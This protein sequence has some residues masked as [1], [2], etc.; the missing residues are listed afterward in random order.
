[1]AGTPKDLESSSPIMRTARSRVPPG[2]KQMTIS[3]GREGY[4]A[5]F[6]I[7]FPNEKNINPINIKIPVTLKI[8]DLILSPP[9]KKFAFLQFII[10]EYKMILQNFMFIAL[11]SFS[12]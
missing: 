7:L 12:Q 8:L 1:M 11:K 5:A 2:A 9:F 6:P 4:S 3:T 10:Y